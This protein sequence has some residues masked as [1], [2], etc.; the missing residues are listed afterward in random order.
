MMGNL[1]ENLSISLR[2]RVVQLAGPDLEKELS[3]KTPR[4]IFQAFVRLRQ[5]LCLWNQYLR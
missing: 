2:K 3:R 4:A 5:Y 1:I